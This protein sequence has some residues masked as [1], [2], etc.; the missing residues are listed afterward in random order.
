MKSGK[1][2]QIPRPVGALI[3]LLGSHSR[4]LTVSET[5]PS[6][7][8]SACA[9]VLK[10]RELISLISVLSTMVRL[11]H[12]RS[13][14]SVFPSSKS[15]RTGSLV[16]AGVLLS[17]I[18]FPCAPSLAW[19]GSPS[20]GL[21][22]TPGITAEGGCYG[23]W[24]KVRSLEQSLGRECPVWDPPVMKM[25]PYG[26]WKTTLHTCVSKLTFIKRLSDNTMP[27]LRLWGSRR[28][29]A[30]VFMSNRERG[31]RSMCLPFTARL[32]GNGVPATC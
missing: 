24:A 21:V 7:L 18:C 13:A 23:A 6:S 27:N 9:F 12:L 5:V 14:G 19:Q 31:R 11:P 10:G 8:L 25:T 28:A 3:K 15:T 17:L 29:K 32:C 4:V 1:A 20:P 22:P 2:S 26:R 30:R 16:F